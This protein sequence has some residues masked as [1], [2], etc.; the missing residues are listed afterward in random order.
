[1]DVGSFFVAYAESAEFEQPTE[2]PLDDTTMNA[3]PT[4]MFCAPF[5][6]ERLDAGGMTESCVL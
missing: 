1:M 2:S 6:D 5:S 3:Q 4:T